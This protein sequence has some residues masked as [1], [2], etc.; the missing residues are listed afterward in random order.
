MHRQI[1]E[2][3][4]ELSPVQQGMLFHTL[5]EPESRLYLEQILLAGPSAVEPR[6]F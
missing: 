3:V 1:V 6:A 5:L 4:Y 2:D